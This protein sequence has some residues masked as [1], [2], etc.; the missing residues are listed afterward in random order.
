MMGL[1]FVLPHLEYM[2]ILYNIYMSKLFGGLVVIF[3]LL[4][5]AEVHA[6]G[7]FNR[8]P[9]S[10][11]AKYGVNPWNIDTDYD[12]YAD[13]WEV[14]SGYCATNPEAVLLGSADCKK[15]TF[16]IRTKTYSAPAAVRAVSPRGIKKFASCAALDSKHSSDFQHYWDEITSVESN[17]PELENLL[18]LNSTNG[19]S[20]LAGL[21][22]E[23]YLQYSLLNDYIYNNNNAVVRHGEYYYQSLGSTGQLAVFKKNAR[24]WQV[25]KTIN[26]PDQ[27]KDI[28]IM[29]INGNNLYVTGHKY[30]TKKKLDWYETRVFVYSLANLEK[31][32]LKRTLSFEGRIRNHTTRNGYLYLAL[33]GGSTDNQKAEKISPNFPFQYKE[34]LGAAKE[35]VNTTKQCN[36]AEYVG[37]ILGSNYL[38]LLAIPLNG[39][40]VGSRVI[41]GLNESAIF[42]GDSLYLL[43]L[44]YNDRSIGD[45]VNDPAAKTEIYKF[46]LAG[47]NFLFDS[48]NT[49]PGVITSKESLQ[50]SNGNLAVVASQPNEANERS[51][52]LYTFDTHLKKLGWYKNF[53]SKELVGGLE[54]KNKIAKVK[55][56]N[57]YFMPNSEKGS[58]IFNLSNPFSPVNLGRVEY[59]SYVSKV[60]PVGS[61]MAIGYGYNTYSLSTTTFGFKSDD[62]IKLAWFKLDQNQLP[63]LVAELNVGR[64]RSYLGSGYDDV[65][66]SPDKSYVAFYASVWDYEGDTTTSTKEVFNGIMVYRLSETAGF[67]F[68]GQID[69]SDF[70]MVPDKVGILDNKLA[71]FSHKYH[72]DNTGKSSRKYFVQLYDFATLEKIEDFEVTK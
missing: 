1:L 25:F 48:S 63:S 29:G 71:L 33:G 20:S 16:D 55:F 3:A 46:S 19:P 50:F 23:N 49:V 68:V 53:V 67:V 17:Y 13:E 9:R 15:G 66:V 70:S 40:Q 28:D 45:F 61:N 5:I 56:N 12:G 57:G 34:R 42:E 26:L 11:W 51:A 64:K 36:E 8:L 31:P 6:A 72:Y 60:V 43:S 38:N 10:D 24:N 27:V 62:G 44:N 41:L 14:R 39:G 18:G 58:M 52:T 69:R 35:K 22:F 2:R 59:P 30:Q 54:Y 21:F 37:R 32:V 7:E 47:S 4:A 65:V